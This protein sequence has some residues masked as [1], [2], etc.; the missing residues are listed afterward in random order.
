MTIKDDVAEVTET[1]ITARYD[2]R[3][4]ALEL[5]QLVEQRERVVANQVIDLAEIDKRI[6]FLKDIQAQ[7]PEYIEPVIEP[8]EVVMS[9]SEPI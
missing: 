9:D 1:K 6:D 3:D 2:N 7:L 5:K 4:V 8:V